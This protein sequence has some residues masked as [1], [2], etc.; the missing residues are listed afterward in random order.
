MV[1]KDN[2][3]VLLLSTHAEPIPL[4]IEGICIQRKEKG[5]PKPVKSRPMHVQYQRNMHGVD[6]FDQL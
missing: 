5:G 6:S 3:P 2:T 4:A 1:W